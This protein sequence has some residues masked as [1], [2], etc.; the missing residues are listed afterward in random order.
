MNHLLASALAVILAAPLSAHEFWIDPVET[1]VESGGTVAADIRVGEK[2]KGAAY[3]YLPPNFERFELVV[4]DQ[5]VPVEGRAGDRPALQMEAPADGLVVVVHQTR[6]YDL[7]YDSFDKFRGFLEHKDALWALDR[8]EPLGL[9]PEKVKEVYTRFGKS[10]IAVGDG[11][12]SDREVGL[13][14]EI[15]AEANPYTD[16][17][18][19]GLPVQVLFEGAPRTDAQVELWARASDGSVT[20]EKYRTDGEGRV[21]LPMAPGTDYLVDAVVFRE[22]TPETPDAAHFESL[23]ASL[24]FTTPDAR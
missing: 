3:A 20:V 21:T 2:F 8:G 22:V 15:V 9:D 18:A 4:G 12:G 23:W 24:T 16:D 19:D 10:L 11:A 7:T 14:T 17:L 6:A 13:L 5:I 1:Q